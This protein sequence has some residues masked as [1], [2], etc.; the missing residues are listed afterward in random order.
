MSGDILPICAEE[1]TQ[2]YELRE[3]I[4]K[5]YFP[6]L[7]ICYITLVK[8]EENKENE[9]DYYLFIQDKINVC[10]V[11]RKDKIVDSVGKGYKKCDI[12]LFTNG[13]ADVI[14]SVYV[15][16]EQC[17]EEEKRYVLSTDVKQ[18]FSGDIEIIRMPT[19]YKTFRQILEMHLSENV[20]KMIDY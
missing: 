8:N 14:T 16:K 18:V 20:M 15:C 9:V 5:K 12:V 19:K 2:E 6:E 10:S 17:E 7:P 4:Q 11:L 13:H 1:Y 3:V